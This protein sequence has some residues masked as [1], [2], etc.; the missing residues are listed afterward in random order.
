MTELQV[1]NT[2]L[3]F[4]VRLL[5]TEFWECLWQV[6]SHVTLGTVHRVSNPTDNPE[7]FE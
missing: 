2:E 1:S 6:C 7:V 5:T 4:I 3:L